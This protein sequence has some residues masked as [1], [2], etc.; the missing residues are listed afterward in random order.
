MAPAPTDS[1][2]EST[3]ADQAG[4]AAADSAASGALGD[5]IIVTAEKRAEGR[6]V[7][8]VPISIVAVGEET[9]VANVSEVSKLAANTALAGS[10]VPGFVNFSIRG[11]GL[12][13]TVRTLDPAVGVFIDGAYVGFGPSSLI[14]NFDIASIESLTNRKFI[15]YPVEIVGLSTLGFGGLPRRY[16]VQLKTRF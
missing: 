9:L 10:S 1:D 7:Q 13:S 12:T 2:T 6:S 15:D 16:G 14:D 3:T 5:E 11:L 4:D 8:E